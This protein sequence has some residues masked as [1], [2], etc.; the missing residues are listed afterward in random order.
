MK[1]AIAVEV[2]ISQLITVYYINSDLDAS[3]VMRVLGFE[4]L[5]QLGD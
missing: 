5:H 1:K 3:D 2:D 4:I